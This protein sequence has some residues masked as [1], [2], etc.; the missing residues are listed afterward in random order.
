MA[1]M[2]HI[3]DGVVVFDAPHPLAEGTEVQV[4]ALVEADNPSSEE[5]PT[6]YERLKSV[7]GSVKG[8][9]S[10]LAENHDHYLHGKPRE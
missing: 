4:I 9:P 10:D 8:L 1:L 3:K 5:I 6:I 7:I 2:G